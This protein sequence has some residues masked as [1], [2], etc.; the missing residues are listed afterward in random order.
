VIKYRPFIFVE[1]RCDVAVSI[2]CLF[3]LFLFYKSTLPA[4][5]IYV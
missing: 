2:V 5:V 1:W 4:D 3:Y